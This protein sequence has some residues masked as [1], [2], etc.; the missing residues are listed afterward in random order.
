MPRVPGNVKRRP[1]PRPALQTHHLVVPSAS[2][3]PC[4]PTPLSAEF[5]PPPDLTHHLTKAN[6]QYVAGGGFGDI[7]KCWYLDGSPKEVRLYNRIPTTYLCLAGSQVAVKAFR[8]S[9]AV[10]GDVNNGSSKVTLCSKQ[11]R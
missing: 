8:F 6:D 1:A 3:S 2:S 11:N 9:C 4:K 10:D 7:Y 5:P